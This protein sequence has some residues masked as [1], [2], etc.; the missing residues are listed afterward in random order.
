VIEPLPLVI[1]IP[2]PAVNVVLVN[3]VPLPMSK[4]P[5]AGVVVKPVP[6]LAIGN[7]PVT[8]VERG[9]PVAFV[10][11]PEAGVPS[12]GAVNVGE[13]ENDNTPLPLLING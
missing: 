5:F 2:V 1:V 7:V 9:N 10:N 3:P 8:P 4:A 11:V 6:P 13:P 12:T